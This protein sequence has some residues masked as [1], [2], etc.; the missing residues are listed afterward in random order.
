ML[1]SMSFVQ[2]KAQDPAFSQFYAC[3]L[4]INPALAGTTECGRLGLN[5]R[6]QWPGISA[7]NSFGITYDQ[8]IEQINSGFGAQIL[9][10]IPDNILHQY[11]I[12]L[13]YSYQIKVSQKFYVRMGLAGGLRIHDFNA[14]NVV[15]PDG[16]SGYEEGITS[17]MYLLPDFT[18]GAYCTYD[19]KYYGGFSVAHFTSTLDLKND[20]SEY[21]RNASTIKYTVHGGADFTLDYRDEYSVSPNFIYQYQDGFN[22]FY[23]GL[24]TN[25]RMIT[26][27]LWYKNNMSFVK[28]DVNSHSMCVLAGISFDKISVGYSYDFNITGIGIKSHGA[29]EISLQWNF[30]VYQG[31]Q[32]RVIKAI[33]S[34]QF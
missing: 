11:N 3:P 19:E 20:N 6:L 12:N 4:Y 26:L 32:K 28:P 13:F 5:Y 27:G 30:C 24:Y 34:P 31:S 7:Y 2:L 23:L 16:T 21:F 14:A 29:H 15:L 10:F 1:V 9:A 25:I 18:L 33:K 22:N 17:K 8:N